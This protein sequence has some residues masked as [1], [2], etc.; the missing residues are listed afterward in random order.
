MIRRELEW[1][2]KVNSRSSTQYQYIG[3]SSSSG[4]RR[5]RGKGEE[6]AAKDYEE[7][8]GKMRRRGRS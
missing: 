2:E 4:W 7:W 1:L 6:G 3:M 5:P 8:R